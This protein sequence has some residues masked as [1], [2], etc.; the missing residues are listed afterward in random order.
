MGKE[1]LATDTFVY[2][3][4]LPD[5]ARTLG[6]ETCQYLEFAAEIN[7]GGVKERH[8]RFYHPL[9]KVNDAGYLD[10]LVKVYLRNFKHPQ[11]GLFT[12]YMDRIQPGA[13][14]HIT[15][16]GGDIVY[17]G[18]SQF[19][20]R[21]KQTLEMVKRRYKNV[22]MIAGGS[23]IAPMFQMVQ[24]VADL[25]PEDRTALSLIYSNRTPVSQALLTRGIV[26]YNP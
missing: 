25:G 11:G 24:T 8:T 4:A 17:K 19:L 3:F 22:G 15:G 14:M 1:E 21:D 6:H 13:V 18:D 26:R 20:V 2:R 10:L 16:I 5:E 9:S 23:G 7:N 12:Q